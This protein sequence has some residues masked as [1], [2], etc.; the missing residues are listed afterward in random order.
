MNK[1]ILIVLGGGFLIAVLVAVM[2]QASLSGSKKKQAA[3]SKPEA[4]VMLV[5]AAKDLKSGDKLDEENMKWQEWPKSGVFPGAVVREKKE[6]TVT[7]AVSGKVQHEVK[8]GEPILSSGVIKDGSNRMAAQLREGMR[9]VSIDVKAS[10]G[11][12]GLVAP[13]DRVDIILNYNSRIKYNGD[14]TYMK[15]LIEANFSKTASETIIENVRVLAVDQ[16]MRVAEESGSGKKATMPKTVTLEVTPK[17]AEVIAVARKAGTMSLA[18]RSLGDETVSEAYTP[19]TTDARI[20]HI[21]DEIYAT[22]EKIYNDN[23]GQ[24][25]NFVRVYHGEEESQ[26]VVQP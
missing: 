8:A 14:D 24:G 18:L 4:K 19:A 22:M 20:T 11:V 21:W 7:E 12:A 26:V 23:S 15:N 25:A 10:T 13:G 1:N 2:V 16:R 9:A 17:G 3:A 5:V 6:Q